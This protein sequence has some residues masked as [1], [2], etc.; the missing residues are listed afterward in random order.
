MFSEDKSVHSFCSITNTLG[1]KMVIF[2][3]PKKSDILSLSCISE[4][5]LPCTKLPWIKPFAFSYSNPSLVGSRNFT[6]NQF[7]SA[8]L[9]TSFSMSPYTVFMKLA[10]FFS[11]DHPKYISK[12]SLVTTS[13][14]QN[15]NW[16]PCLN[17]W[18]ID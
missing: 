7:S 5:V 12:S 3:P 8:N 18:A 1:I 16:P 2:P 9:L 4:V 10:L 14:V 6:S 15:A 17:S 11:S 13:N